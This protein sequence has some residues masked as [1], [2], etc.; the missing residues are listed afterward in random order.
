MFQRI[1]ILKPQYTPA[2]L[3][4]VL[5]LL[6]S[7]SISSFARSND[8]H[9]LLLHSYHSGYSWTDDIN[10]GVV[11]ELQPNDSDINLY[12]EYMDTKK[13]SFDAE[14][15]NLLVKLLEHKYSR[16][17]PNLIIVSDNN[18]F[19][20]IRK[21]HNQLFPEVPVVFCGIGAFP[22]KQLEDDGQIT[23]VAEVLDA[24]R[25][26]TV[27]RDF[28]PDI[29]K[30]FVIR[31]FQPTGIAAEAMIRKQLE[32]LADTLDI[33]YVSDIPMGQLLDEVGHLP[34]DSV[35]LLASYFKDSSGKLY[36]PEELTHLISERSSVPVYGLY[37][38]NLGQGIIGGYLIN[39][40]AQ[41]QAAARLG[42]QILAGQKARQIP[43]DKTR[44][45]IP[46]FD[47]LELQRF[48]LQNKK[49]PPGSTIINQEQ[50]QLTQTEVEWMKAHPHIRFAPAPHYPPIEFFD[51]NNVY[52]GIAADFVKLM[53]KK[54]G[55]KPDIIQLDSWADLIEQTKQHKI[56]MWG[57]AAK[58]DE[59]EKYMAFTEPYIRLPEVIIVRKEIQGNLTIPDLKGKKVVVIDGYASQEYL[60]NTFPEIS[61]FPV[62]DIETGL[63]MV[64]F[65]TADAIVATDA[66]A[67]YYIQKNGLTNLR[68]AGD[69]GYEWFLRF[70]ARKDWPELASIIQKGLNA[71]T[72]EEKHEIFSQWI[73]LEAPKWQLSREQII[74]L[75]AVF[76]GGMV[77]TVIFWNF[78]LRRTV[79][80]R[81]REL[82]STVKKLDATMKDMQLILNNAQIG[83]AHVVDRKIQLAN[84]MLAKLLNMNES[85]LEGQSTRIFFVND[86]DYERI[87]TAYRTQL[88]RGERYETELSFRRGET[89]S[90]MARLIGQ[91]IDPEQVKQGVTW[92]IQ[93]ITAQKELEQRLTDL[94][95]TDPLTGVS[96]RRQFCI[97]GDREIRRSKR[98]G[99]PLSVLMLDIDHFKHIN[100]CYGHAFGDE[101]LK[102][103]T[104]SVESVLREHDILGRIGGE[105]FAVVMP[106]TD[107][108]AAFTV[109]ERIRQL[110]ASGSLKKD[111]E[112]I[113]FTVSIG[114]VTSTNKSNM[115]DDLEALLHLADVALYEAK[116]SGRDRV[117][118]HQM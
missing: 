79:R 28:N 13:T 74:G 83:I 113:S 64:S 11:N 117:L 37:R 25:T 60:E 96:N 88:A 33:K 82:T 35:V 97:L 66:V 76:V 19:D 2:I 14:Y 49:L 87:G 54:I 50:A 98:T 44:Q 109:A 75:L 71:I 107:Q 114:L 69:S 102:F 104:N 77:I 5:I 93:D 52:R 46:M 48:G 21:H 106:E 10:K 81:T 62:P 23:G 67:L 15:E 39:G 22:D 105:E 16:I 20:F 29:K 34:D 30:V 85:D 92:L 31:D 32:P 70:A 40:Y 116:K 61:Y 3:T 115:Q 24:Q 8:K 68:V 7:L 47:Y 4:G 84:P 100:D 27:A 41:G 112:L 17:K 26:L 53:N 99:L 57:A 95:T 51:E 72:E 110:V 18:A 103:F 89:D 42:K 36:E 94:A 111:D 58:N 86:E 101:A 65:G 9:V 1:T 80:K 63:R 90:F 118:S 45:S 56:D 73:S 78:N 108:E 55:L 91:A 6:L 43:I 12:V 38:F 59:R